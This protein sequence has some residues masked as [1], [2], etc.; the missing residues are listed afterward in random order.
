MHQTLAK[1]GAR[2]EGWHNTVQAHH[3]SGCVARFLRKSFLFKEEEWRAERSWDYV[4]E[5]EWRREVPGRRL[6]RLGQGGLALKLAAYG[7]RANRF[8]G[9]GSVLLLLFWYSFISLESR[10]RFLSVGSRISM[11]ITTFTVPFKGAKVAVLSFPQWGLSHGALL[12]CRRTSAGLSAVGK[13]KPTFTLYIKWDSSHSPQKVIM[14]I[15]YGLWAYVSLLHT[16]RSPGNSAR[17]GVVNNAQLFSVSGTTLNRTAHAELLSDSRN[18]INV[19]SRSGET[20]HVVG[21]SYSGGISTTG[22]YSPSPWFT[23]SIKN[24]FTFKLLSILIPCGNTNVMISLCVSLWKNHER[25][26]HPFI[27]IHWRKVLWRLRTKIVEIGVVS[28]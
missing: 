15:K 19:S 22:N 21:H 2:R 8:Q 26:S 5:E 24:E 28:I 12:P 20:L 13:V 14:N 6:S 23:S 17:H 16:T 1:P 4:R 10:H 27:A 7:P 9:N 3:Q 18:F 25:K 11:A